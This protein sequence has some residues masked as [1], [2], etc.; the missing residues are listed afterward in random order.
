[1]ATPPRL[2]TRPREQGGQP[3][4]ED[5][6]LNPVPSGATGV[7]GTQPTTASAEFNSY[8]GTVNPN[9]QFLGG[10]PG[11]SANEFGRMQAIGAD[12]GRNLGNLS[13]QQATAGGAAAGR[14]CVADTAPFRRRRRRP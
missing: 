13:V 7:Y 9:A 4:K 12:A 8:Q 11:F 10:E 5:E 3:V 1:M 2:W 6:D 14:A